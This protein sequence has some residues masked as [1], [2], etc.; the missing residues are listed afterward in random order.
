M[1]RSRS[2]E[3]FLISILVICFA[4][5]WTTSY[6]GLSLSLGAFL[7]GLI[8][9]ESEYSNEAMANV[10]PF[11]EIFTSFFFI[12]IGML[13]NVGFLMEHPVQILLMTVSTLLLKALIVAGAVFLM[14]LP[15]RT[16][17]IV[18]LSLAQVGEFA[19]ILSRVG[20]QYGL[21]DDITN[22]Y[23]LSISILTM[24]VTPTLIA[25][26]HRITALVMKAPVPERIKRRFSYSRL[27]QQMPVE[28]KESYKGHLI[29]VG[30][31]LNGMN[32]AKA[33]RS[34]E[35]PYLILE[36]NPDIVAREK[37]K[38]EPII[39]GDAV[40]QS[41][42]EQ[43]HLRKAKVVAV[44]ISD[45]VST[46]RIVSN[47][48]RMDPTIHIIVRTRYVNEV[49]ELHQ[50]GADEVIPEEFETSVEIFSRV[51]SLYLIPREEIDR[52]AKSIRQD[53]YEMFR[54]SPARSISMDNLNEHID[55]ADIITMKVGPSSGFIGQ[56]LSE[57]DIRRR[58]DV[59]LLAI[60]RDGEIRTNPSGDET[61]Q[62]YDKLILFGD[63][64]K[65]QQ[66]GGYVVEGRTRPETR[67]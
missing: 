1:V 9:S 44:A 47:V 58:F 32:L 23:F 20:V 63:P 50:L 34:I 21:L 55:E 7:A 8:I 40:H 24:A 65:I 57:I 15:L 67:T 56:K 38:G 59:T 11:Y 22:Q 12:S 41:V 19:F 3:L 2:R 35:I 28:K 54:S 53:S 26:S 45:P 17:M 10:A 31:G 27:Q 61:I 4:I 5:A 39:F 6:I 43:V 13:L 62:A 30:A 29:I 64:E 16:V 51:M 46:R 33:A 49:R 48:R 37:E 14:R 42:L 60:G 52:F 36:L 66:F 25:M 18:G